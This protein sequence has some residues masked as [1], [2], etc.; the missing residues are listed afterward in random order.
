[1]NRQRGRFIVVEGLEG[2]GKSTAMQTLQQF[3]QKN[4]Q[5]VVVVREPGGTRVG[6]IVRTLVKEHLGLD[7]RT[8]LLLLYAARVQLIQEIIEPALHTGHW[9]LCD[10]FEL[11]TFAY[12]GGGRQMDPA[13]IETLS[14]ICLQGFKP[15][16]TFFLDISPEKGLDRAGKR[17]QLDRI[18]CESDAFFQRVYKAYQDAVTHD[19]TVI[20]IDAEQSL[21]QVQKALLHHLE[22]FVTSHVSS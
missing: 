22:H 16:L 2:A 14:G 17:G 11:S 15:D 19:D 18:E 20:R 21:P 6:E 3:F 12:Q 9:V 5:N 10:R 8:E 13:L 7:N 1:M 4:L